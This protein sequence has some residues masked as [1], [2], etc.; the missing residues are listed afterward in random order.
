MGFLVP[1]NDS[2]TSIFDEI[3]FLSK[4]RGESKGAFETSLKRLVPLAIEIKKEII[5]CRRT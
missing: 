1:A 5:T 4:H 3:G 2:F